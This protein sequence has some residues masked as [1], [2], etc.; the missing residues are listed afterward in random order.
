MAES[1]WIC[2]ER[3]QVEVRPAKGADIVSIVDRATGIDVMARSPWGRRELAA[4]LTTGDSQ[5]DWLA[6]YGDRP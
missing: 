6:R 5:L 2:S 1:L 4:A 3:L